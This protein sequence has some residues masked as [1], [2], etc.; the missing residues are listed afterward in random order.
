MQRS[1]GQSLE[2]AVERVRWSRPVIC[3]DATISGVRPLSVE[4]I[5]DESSATID[6]PLTLFWPS[7]TS[8]KYKFRSQKPLLVDG[9]GG[10]AMILLIVSRRSARVPLVNA[11]LNPQGGVNIS[12]SKGAAA[13]C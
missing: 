13:L 2:A 11:A 10:F 12:S 3:V 8:Q 1:Y 7:H 4:P 5:A 6:L 9:G